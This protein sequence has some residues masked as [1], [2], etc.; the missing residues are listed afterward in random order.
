MTACPCVGRSWASDDVIR[1]IASVAD[2]GAAYDLGRDVCEDDVMVAICGVELVCDVPFCVVV[3]V[4]AMG[5]L[6]ALSQQEVGRV[7]GQ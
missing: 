1:C 7:L 3:V 2:T 5:N 6:G 4:L